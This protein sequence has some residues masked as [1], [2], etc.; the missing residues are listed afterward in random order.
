[1]FAER[2]EGRGGV[3]F[4]EESSSFP[5]RIKPPSATD[6]EGERPHGES[7]ETLSREPAGDPS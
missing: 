1:M 5:R 7:R 6:M 3:L 4:Y 2:G